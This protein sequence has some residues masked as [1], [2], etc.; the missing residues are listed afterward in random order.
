MSLWTVSLGG[1]K[2]CIPWPWTWPQMAPPAIKL[3]SFCQ[4]L[5][6]FRGMLFSWNVLSFKQT[7]K[8]FD[9][10]PTYLSYLSTPVRYISG[11]YTHSTMVTQRSRSWSWMIDSCSFCSMSIGPSIYEA[12]LFQTLTLKNQGQGHGCSQRERSHIVGPVSNWVAS[13][14]F[15]INQTNNSWH[16]AISKFDHEKIKVR[17]VSKV[18]V[19]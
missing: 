3:F 1:K 18:K 17:V 11:T 14:S 15:H 13:F 5:T 16:G 10:T 2:Q 19:T 7:T 8:C 9:G 4:I 6:Y 12:M